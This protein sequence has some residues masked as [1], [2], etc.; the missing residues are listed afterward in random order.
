MASVTMKNV[1]KDYTMFGGV[2]GVSD[3]NL[4][5]K[6]G[7]VIVLV[8]PSGCGKTSALFMLAGLEEISKGEVYFDDRLINDVHPKDRGV[9]LMF[10]NCALFPYMTAFENIAFGLKPTDMSA[11]EISGKVYEVAKILA[12]DHLLNRKPDKLSGGQK[13]RVALGRAL[14]RRN[15]VVCLDEPL[16]NL[17]AK[18]RDSMRSELIRLHQK[19]KTTF[20][21]VTHDQAEAMA[22]ADRIVVMKEG[23]IQQVGTPEELYFHPV[24]LFVAGFIGAPQM[25]LG[26]VKVSGQDG[27]IYINLGDIKIK[28]PENK[29]DKASAYIG[30]EIIAG[31]RPEDMYEDGAGIFDVPVEVR[32]FLGD[33][34]YLHCSV[35]GDTLTVRVSPDCKAR[36]GDIIKLAVNPDK[37]H[38]FDKQ[39]ELAID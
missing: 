30:K 26:N 1:Y 28:L 9:V 38:L 8:G 10:H 39:T 14:V 15:E 25:N 5:I 21:Y 6:D 22:I 7:E 33:R 4:E 27:D 35:G 36:A 34:V 37:I 3:F 20:I 2:I 29:A 13:Q 19:F 32:E 12:I 24:N 31:V 23:F 18:L 17:D 16:S 11:E